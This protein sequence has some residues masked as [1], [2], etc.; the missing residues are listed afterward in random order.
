MSFMSF[1]DF[2]SIVALLP[3]PRIFLCIPASAADTAAVNSNGIKTV[4]ANGLMTFFINSNPVFGN[5]K[6]F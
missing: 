2:I 4:L 3:D 6:S 1:N 5:G